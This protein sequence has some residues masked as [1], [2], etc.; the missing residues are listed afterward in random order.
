M[1][2]H[3]CGF[4]FLE[5]PND[6]FAEQSFWWVWNS[7]PKAHFDHF[8]ERSFCRKAAV[9]TPGR[10]DMIGDTDAQTLRP[11]VRPDMTE[12]T[13]AQTLRPSGRPDMT[14][15]TDAKLYDHPRNLRF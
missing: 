14:E 9:R 5:A 2:D 7:A 4:R 8:G 12:A 11:S 15:G 6:H 1:I 13:D 3:F 10:P